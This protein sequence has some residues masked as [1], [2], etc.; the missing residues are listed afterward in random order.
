MRTVPER[1]EPGRTVAQEY[2]FIAAPKEDEILTSYGA[3][4]PALTEFGRL[5]PISRLALALLKGI[6]SVIPNYGV[7]ILVL[8]LI[9]RIIL[10][11]LTRMSQLSMTRMQK[12]QPH[13]AELQRKY[14]NDKPKLAQEQM[15]LFRRYGVSPLSGC[16]PTFLQLPVLIALFYALRGAIALR[17]AGFLW[18]KDLSRPDT[19]F[20]FP[21]QILLLGNKGFNP[22]PILMGGA[23]FLNQQFTPEPAGEQALRQHRMMKWFLLLFVVMFYSAPSGL[24]LYWTASTL[25]GLLERWVIDR[26]ASAIELKP[27][28]A[29]A[30]REKREKPVTK[31]S[32]PAGWLEK[33][34]R[35][36][37]GAPRARRSGKHGSK[38]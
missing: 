26:K 13:V 12:L 22:L 33:L 36:L 34:Q 27:V 16:W 7:A 35:R 29:A 3:G 8:T 11:P 31:G 4:M 24:C 21:P 18:V 20:Y 23:M 17:Q 32:Q 5:A 30:P 9:V 28:D 25:V 10:H 19:L 2:R 38:E 37:E 6:R 1:L 15:A 14:A